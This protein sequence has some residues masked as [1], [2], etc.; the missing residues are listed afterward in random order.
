M[1]VSRDTT[2]PTHAKT[3][4][5][6]KYYF[7]FVRYMYYTLI[8]FLQALPVKLSIFLS[9]RETRP[10]FLFIL[11]VAILSI[12]SYFSSETKSKQN[13]RLKIQK[14]VNTQQQRQLVLKFNK[15]LLFFLI[16]NVVFILSSPRPTTM[17]VISHQ[18]HLTA[19]NTKTRVVVATNMNS[20]ANNKIVPRSIK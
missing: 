4:H 13:I 1:P 16:I 19:N 17:P 2:K 14:K 18:I 7:C 3:Y 9:G 11:I 8:F 5:C 15:V 10:H 6:I 20:S 12:F